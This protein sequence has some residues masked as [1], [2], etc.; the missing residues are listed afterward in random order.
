MARL[1]C[2]LAGE[3]DWNHHPLAPGRYACISPIYGRSERTRCKNSTA[4]PVDT[5]VIQDSGA[6]CDGPLSRLSFE[7]ALARQVAHA[8]SYGHKSAGGKKIIGYAPQITH[9]ASYDLL[10]DEKWLDGERHK[11]RWTEEEAQSA[12]AET[13][14][15]ARYLDAHRNGLSLILSA[16]GV[17]AQQYLACSKQIVPLL[18][19]GDIFGLGGWCIT[20]LLKAKIHPIFQQTMHEV[21]P[22]LGQSGVKWAHIWGVIYPEA[23]GELQCLCDQYGIFLSTDSSG[24]SVNPT[25]GCWGYAEWRDNQ[26]RAAPIL[27]SCRVQTLWK[28]KTPACLPGT[29]CRGLER[30]RHVELTG[31]YLE[32]IHETRHYGLPWTTM[33]RQMQLVV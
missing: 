6:F 18:Q 22:F 21:I 12:V 31:R 29:P 5:E 17:S 27:E 25:R 11:S 33:P 14:A 9:R 19:D 28:E 10:I 7:E 32:S 3:M 30:A 26:Y 13:V 16:Q 24:P 15:A 20:G 23:I 4:V 8:Q 2:G 1:Y